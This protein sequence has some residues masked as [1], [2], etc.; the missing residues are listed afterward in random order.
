MGLLRW[1][2]VATDVRG[3]KNM[4]SAAVPK[5]PDRR[6]GPS[7]WRIAATRW[8]NRAD[9]ARR[10]LAGCAPGTVA[11]RR[12][13]PMKPAHLLA[14]VLLAVALVVPRTAAALD[15]GDEE[16][17]RALA[18]HSDQLWNDRDAEALSTLFA[19]DADLAIGDHT[20]VAS[21]E[22]IRGYFVNSFA[23]MPTD[24]RHVM[25]VRALRE[26][27]PG[28][29][30]ADGEVRIER[31]NADGT[32]TVLRRFANTTLLVRAGGDWRFMAVRAVPVP[33]PAAPA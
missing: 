9:A 5:V 15:A 19:A 14:I 2:D 27:A 1:V 8:R 17:L 22:R 10:R 4:T 20:Q 26:V 31:A 29:V 16:V 21:R 25:D 12:N 13:F 28:V 11:G 7:P 30:L 3:R 32:R 24:L 33:P 6:I 23:Q 18:A